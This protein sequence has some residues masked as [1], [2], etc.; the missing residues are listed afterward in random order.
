MSEDLIR[1][2]ERSKLDLLRRKM[3]Q[4][5]KPMNII[6]SLILL[7]L[8]FFPIFVQA[9]F[10]L[11]IF[12][13]VFM[14][15]LIGVG[16]NIIGG[17]AGQPALGNAL[18]FGLGAYTS[19]LMLK[20]WGISPWVGLLVGM[21]VAS[22]SAALIGLPTFRLRGHYFAIATLALTEVIRQVFNW[23]QL[24]GGANGVILPVLPE[25]FL[26]FE[27]HS[28][29]VP[30]YYII[31]TFLIVGLVV[32]KLLEGTRLGYY[33]R[34]IKNDQRAASSLGVNVTRCKTIAFM[35]SAAITA[36]AGTF[37]AQF[38]LY[39]EPLS[40]FFYLTS[41][42]AVLIATVGGL[43]WIW[44]PFVGAMIL[45]PLSEL[46]RTYL[47]GTGRAADLMLYGFI[48]MILAAWEPR[49]V[50]GIIQRFTSKAARRDM[51]HETSS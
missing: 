31:F 26:N 49:G 38:V 28:S 6:F 18:F 41:L 42:Q 8:L 16:W 7:G 37:Y 32:N 2:P 24:V 45:I 51:V 9:P 34:A 43:G 4:F 3:K 40:A 17:Y 25:S 33:L 15:G 44:G 12:I 27:F 14:Y 20:W 10:Y 23:W 50:L 1:S 35:V 13:F 11:N 30:Y 29:R 36:A 39:F 22:L 19:G 48:V 47:A 5:L 46:T 21:L